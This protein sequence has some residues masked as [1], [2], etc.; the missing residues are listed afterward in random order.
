MAKIT[1]ADV[2]TRKVA[3]VI[4][5]KVGIMVAQ[6]AKELVPK[7][8][9]ALRNSIDYRVILKPPYGGTVVIGTNME[10]GIFM[11]YGRLP[12]KLSSEEMQNLM[13]WSK[14]HG[15]NPWGVIHAIEKRGIPVGTIEK[16]IASPINSPTPTGFRPWL[17]PAVFQSKD[18]VK[19]LIRKEW[20]AYH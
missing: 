13:E 17:R 19:E 7:D 1:E 3:T 2:I 10:Y 11:E 4:L 9:G 8:T 12:G 15:A 5:E 6:K 18:D 14:R 16:P 20:E